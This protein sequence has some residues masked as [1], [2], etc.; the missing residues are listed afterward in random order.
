VI[1][2]LSCLLPRLR[3][4]QLGGAEPYQAAQPFAILK[5]FLDKKILLGPRIRRGRDHLA[6]INTTGLGGLD[7]G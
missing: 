6:D 4:R 7:K 2:F 5:L 1:L 3:Q